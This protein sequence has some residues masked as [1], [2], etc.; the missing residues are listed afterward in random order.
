MKL[1]KLTRK[2]LIGFGQYKDL[3][4]QQL[5]DLKYYS[6][7]RWCYFC[8]SHINFFEDIL[9]ELSIIGDYVIDKPSTNPDLLAK[10]KEEKYLKMGG[11]MKLKQNAKAKKQIKLTAIRERE[12]KKFMDKKVY[13]TQINHGK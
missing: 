5:L 8:N 9:E 1:R 12:S 7:L 13:L 11:L 4:V 3:T 2:S 10:L 6:Y